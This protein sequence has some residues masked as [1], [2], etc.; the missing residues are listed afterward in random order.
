MS[1]PSLSQQVAKLERTVGQPLLVRLGR[2]VVPTDAGRILA[3]RAA[4]IL[5]AVDDAARQ[6]KSSAGKPGGRLAIG[7]IPTVAPYLL[8]PV[9]GQFMKQ[10]P[11]VE[12][13]VREDVTRELVAATTAGDLDLAI[14]AQ[15]VAD[16]RLR[17]EAL[18]LRSRSCW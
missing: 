7:A 5:A 9:L 17:T 13:T 10:C 1:Q 6:L 3:E 8:P 12:L 16:D 14:M 11:G 2:G 15:P 4:A 18:L